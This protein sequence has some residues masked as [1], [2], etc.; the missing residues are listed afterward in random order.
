MYKVWA[1]SKTFIT[2]I[3][4]ITCTEYKTTLK[5]KG[6]FY[7][8]TKIVDKAT[9]KTY[10]TKQK[11]KLFKFF[12]RHQVEK[13]K[14]NSLYVDSRYPS[15]IKKIIVLWP[16]KKPITIFPPTSRSCCFS[17]SILVFLCL[18]KNIYETFLKSR[19]NVFN[20]K[21][22]KKFVYALRAQS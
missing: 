4:F 22:V 7:L 14:G 1:T 6:F 2:I 3:Y 19:L 10:Q 13:S 20:Y 5:I 11:P 12:S 8:N 21:N 9:V 15:S 17:K 16:G 18:L